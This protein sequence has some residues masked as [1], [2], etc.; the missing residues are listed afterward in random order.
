[1]KIDQ[2]FEKC[3]ALSIKKRAD[4]TGSNDA[5]EN[6]KRSSEIQSWF[7]NDIDKSYVVLIGTKLARLASLLG[8]D[9]PPQNESV[10]DTFEDLINYC[11]LWAERRTEMNSRL[12]MPIEASLPDQKVFRIADNQIRNTNCFSCGSNISDGAKVC[13]GRY[14]RQIH[15]HCSRN[16]TNQDW[17]AFFNV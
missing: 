4:Y 11:A 7:K 8:S 15:E 17:E 16:L 12:N 2:I 9:K 6:F 1:M 10:Q 5:H 3:L 13:Y 14:N